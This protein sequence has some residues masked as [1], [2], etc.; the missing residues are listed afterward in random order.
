MATIESTAADVAK[1]L[2]FSELK[3]LQLKVIV[4]FVSGRDVFAILPTGYG[5]LIIMHV[6]H[7]YKL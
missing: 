3:E 5:K 2:G 1:E 6:S 4:D 7:A